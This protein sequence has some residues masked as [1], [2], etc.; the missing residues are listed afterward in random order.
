MTTSIPEGA[1]RLWLL[2]A[3]Y[4]AETPFTAP[5][6]RAADA[7]LAAELGVTERTARRYR[8]ALVG[9]GILR[10]H[11]QEANIL[12]L[13]LLRRPFASAS[14]APASDTRG[15]CREQQRPLSSW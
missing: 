9:A 11:W 5:G 6:S 2:L 13:R 1:E 14:T 10:E 15:R 12:E 4:P 8:A 7:D 3:R